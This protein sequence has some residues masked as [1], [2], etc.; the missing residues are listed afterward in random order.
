MKKKAFVFIL[1]ISGFFIYGETFAQDQPKFI[2][3]ANLDLSVKPGD[4]FYLYANG[5]WLKNTP[6]PPSKTRWGSFNILAEASSQA[7]K[8]L[9]ENASSN[10]GTNELMKRVGDFYA[11]AMDSINMEKL[12]A[13]PIKAYLD[14]ITKLGTK[15]QLIDHINY[16]RAHSITSPLYRIGVNQDA[17]KVTQYIISIGQGGTSLPDR[18][19][20]LKNDPRSQTIRK[21]YNNY[22]TKLFIL[23]GTDETTENPNQVQL[24]HKFLLE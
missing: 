14:E 22:V 16:L 20:Y 8:G 7:L 12:G 24:F 5:N 10:P 18:D 6:I 3:P 19:Y 15:E 9:L 11:S 2:D 4:N 17:K 1:A 23:C 21:E 13:Q